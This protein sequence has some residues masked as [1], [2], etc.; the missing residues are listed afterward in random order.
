MF[1]NYFVSGPQ[2]FEEI[3]FQYLKTIIFSSKEITHM[4]NEELKFQRMLYFTYILLVNIKEVSTF[5]SRLYLFNL[6]LLIN[7]RAWPKSATAIC[8]N[9]FTIWNF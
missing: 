6:S 7:M 8:K 2:I 5:M 1:N 4:V 3:S 9:W